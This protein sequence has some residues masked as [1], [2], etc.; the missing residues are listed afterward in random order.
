M[1]RRQDVRCAVAMSLMDRMKSAVFVM[2]IF[3]GGRDGGP[4]RVGGLRRLDA[5]GE[6]S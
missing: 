1:P 3:S 6:G 5:E 2:S 4:G